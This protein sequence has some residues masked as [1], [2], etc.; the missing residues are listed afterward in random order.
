MVQWPMRMS[1]MSIVCGL[2]RKTMNKNQLLIAEA[3]NAD[4]WIKSE[5][6]MQVVTARLLDALGLLYCHVPN[7]RKCTPRQGA[8]L[9]RAGVKSGVPDVLIFNTCV[10]VNV[11]TGTFKGC[12]IELKYDK[13]RPT[14]AQKQWLADLK[15][16]GW[17]VDL[18][19][20]MV[21]VI[22]ILERCGYI[23]ETEVR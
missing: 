22:A 13:N 5:Y 8:R 15:E 1:Y 3:L 14:P 6:D 23:E 18:A 20:S 4:R 19:F 10:D 21:D 17:Y 11:A 7:E 16:E 9:K 12:A 2:L